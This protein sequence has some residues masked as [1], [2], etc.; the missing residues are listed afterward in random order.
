MLGKAKDI[1]N[2]TG[3]FEFGKE[4]SVSADGVAPARA[5]IEAYWRKLERNHTKDDESLLGLP[6]TYLVPASEEGHEFDFDE[7][8]YWDSYFM[9]QGML[10]DPK[11]K[12]LV[13]GM[14][15]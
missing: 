15:E 1:A 12:E 11:R 9:I 5:Y 3:L 2:M 10:D 7:M 14:L 13:M 4:R 6:K 8:Y